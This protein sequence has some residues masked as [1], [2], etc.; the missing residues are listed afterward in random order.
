MFTRLGPIPQPLRTRLSILQSFYPRVVLSPLRRVVFLTHMS[1]FR[2][3]SSCPSKILELL[4]TLLVTTPVLLH[5]SSFD[6]PLP[7]E[8]LPRSRR[9]SPLLVSTRSSVPRPVQLGTGS[10]RR[11]PGTSPRGPPLQSVCTSGVLL[12]PPRPV[13]SCVRRDSGSLSG[14][15]TVFPVPLPFRRTMSRPTPHSVPRAPLSLHG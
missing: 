7:S 4:S 1:F 12:R 6:I 5:Q 11:P 2:L 9:G 8:T 10:C 14:A 15:P 3:P 13:V